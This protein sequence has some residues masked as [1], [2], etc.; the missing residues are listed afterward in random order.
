MQSIE[1]NI[2]QAVDILVN[3]AI[4][5]APYT[6]TILAQIISC[7]DAT[8]GKYK[9]KYQDNVCYAYS[10][11]TNITYV[12]GTDVY[13]LVPNGNLDKEKTIIGTTKK[14]GINYISVVEGDEA[15]EYIGN[16]CITS[17]ESFTL[18]SYKSEEII[19]YDKNGTDNKITLDTQRV[20]E[21]I[22]NSS[23]IICGARFRTVLEMEQRFQGNY[24]I[25]FKLDFID[26]ATQNI[27]TK[28]FIIDVNRMIGNPYKFV[29]E[30]RQYGIFEIDGANFDSVSSISI[31]VQDF[32]NKDKDIY[33]IF[34]RD[35][36]LY[37]AERLKESDLNSYSLSILTPQGTFFDELS[38]EREERTLQA[39]VK[40]RGKIVNTDAQSLDY[41][42][43]IEHNGITSDSAYYNKYGGQGWKCLNEFNILKGNN[44]DPDIVEWIPGSD[45][46]IVR[47]NEVIAKEVKYK[48]AAV[49]NGT[50]IS[51]SI[52]IKNLDSDYNISIIS[53]SGTKFYY[54][55]GHPTLTC[56]VG[57]KEETGYDYVWAV[58]NNIGQFTT[59]EVTTEAN[60]EY[61]NAVARLEA[62]Q[63]EIKSA[64][65]QTSAQTQELEELRQ[66]LTNSKK[67]CRIESNKIH[68]LQINSITNFST[69]KCS[70][71]QE[72]LFL[73]TAS[74]VITN[75]LE[76][77]GAYSLVINDGTQV[78]KYDENGLSPASSAIEKPIV[79][80][81][82]TFTIY[83]N[84][85][86]PIDDDVAEHC[87]IR[88]TVP[89][90]DTL[91]TIPSQYVSS[92]ADPENKTET[93]NDLMSFAYKIVD[94]YDITKTRNNIQLSVDYKG[95]KLMAYTNFTFVKEGEPGTNG[96]EYVCK[97]LPNTHDK[98]VNPMVINGE[99]NY[100]PINAKKWFKVE[101]WESGEQI[102]S[103]VESTND[104]TV[105]WS[106]LRN[107]Y[108]S[109]ILDPSHLEV[110][111]NGEFTCIDYKDGQHVAD[112]IKVEIVYNNKVYYS[113][114]VL[115]VL[116]VV[117][118]KYT[119][120]LKE[121]TGFK[122]ATYTSD[123]QRPKY[124][125][126]YP[127]EI[128]IK[129]NINGVWEDV[130]LS[131]E[132][133]L[134]YNITLKGQIYNT[135]T[136]KW[137]NE[138]LLKH[139]E[140]N[141]LLK[142]NQIKI[143][144][145]DPYDGYCV[146]NGFECEVLKGNTVLLKLHMP[147]H[148]ML[149]RYGMS[150]L[151][152]WD[153]NS[154]AINEEQG[155][156]LSPQ[157][158]AGIKEDDNSFTG[159]LI[160]KV[161]D[162]NEGNDAVGLLGY[163]KGQRSIFLDAETGKAEFGTVNRGKIIIDP[164]TDRAIIQSGN[165]DAGK[166]GM[167]IDFTTPQI[168]FGSEN[169][170]VNAEGHITAKGGGTIAGWNIA[171]KELYQGKVGMSSNN[172][173]DDGTSND[174]KIAFWAGRTSGSK[175][176]APFRVNFDGNL[177]T[178]KITADGGTVGGWDIDASKISSGNIVLNKGG[179]IGY[180]GKWFID[181][182]GHAYFKDITLSDSASYGS[183]LDSPFS[184]KCID[185]IESISAKYIYAQY[186]K[187]MIADIDTLQADL[188]ETNELVAT[189]A[190]ISEL[191]AA[192]ARISKIEAD[193]ITTSELK[194]H[195]ISADKLTAG[196]VNG[197]SV[198]WKTV[199]Y[200]GWVSPV[201]DTITDGDG[202]SIAVVTD[203]DNDIYTIFTIC[204]T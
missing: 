113:T 12:A 197:K 13:V 32:P 75:S 172:K 71:Y 191:N 48:C 177:Y 6:S 79:L 150:A 133:N 84:L 88:W 199:N 119:A 187:A 96:T 143:K 203:L 184:G 185:H 72:G 40:V 101:L 130:S 152:G 138:N 128:I 22:K 65:M 76:V 127:F 16:N 27:V 29:Q 149:N 147:I 17:S 9:I 118:A 53:D 31:F 175:D 126:S 154:I 42:W 104:F 160:G 168:L 63:S 57:G 85:G 156:I 39:Q 30:T 5:K 54:D 19:L 90:S 201:K 174:K 144:P 151:N 164:T 60:N 131:T 179:S 33:D 159:V 95:M 122:F 169:F 136:K 91:L 44:D 93:F 107:K 105:S 195:S 170:E 64:G 120:L 99:I 2:C 37:S 137:I 81:A 103:G 158:G 171:D 20:N 198:S 139:Y 67:L 34:I 146:S 155:F 41:Y 86:N 100:T 121:N 38:T 166:S 26:N 55:I 74:I 94:R 4:D 132:E 1:N 70:V 66:Y 52:I 200:I 140:K 35:I 49:Y 97:I 98:N 186:L 134:K 189:K 87:D 135:H 114:Y 23:T 51:K 89:T 202:N 92:S 111:S 25:V 167:M 28:D 116:K 192:V 183:S 45:K 108:K 18:S 110:T 204:A 50:V 106:I 11:N 125:D 109:N 190:S 77:E 46:L 112:I 141:E 83:D 43:F 142:K 58:E 14:L 157:V 102:F 73:G 162:A 161:D 163:S 47:K 21:Y 62:L 193:Y 78:F 173:N 153:G 15:Y 194:A 165:Y 68:N 80:K 129:K 148:L 180:D 69:Y 176:S 82:L 10:D 56:L 7:V 8:I 196:T 181:S 124:D 61:N 115:P 123:G 3:K 117:N 178:N 188:I 145:L 182:S 36:E 24:G 59:L